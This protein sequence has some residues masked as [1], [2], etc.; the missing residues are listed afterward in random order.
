MLDDK[1]L[2]R[3]SRHILLPEIDLEG[4]EK[5]QQARVLVIGCG[6]L[7][8][9]AAPLLAAAGIGELILVDFDTIDL[10]NLQRQIHFKTEDVGENK[11]E[12]L[13]KH[14]HNLNPN[15]AIYA[16]PEKANHALLLDLVKN[17]DM[18]LDCT[19]N[20]AIRQIINQ[21]A[22][23]HKIPLI[24]GSAIRFEGQLAI[25]DFRDEKSGCYHCLFEGAHSDDG[26]CALLGVFAPVLQI[27]GAMQAQEALKIILELAIKVNQM[28]IYNALTGD[29]Q[30]FKFIRN[31]KCPVCCEKEVK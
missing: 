28:K 8:N 26:A 16:V 22:H 2:L 9:A 14:L 12:I 31:P 3:Y 15:V 20:F 5:I 11:A 18:V 7:G 21:V 30:V 23:D 27:V 10:S 1:A 4:Q 29:W 17:V 6:G 19:D 25:Y 13:K 24:S